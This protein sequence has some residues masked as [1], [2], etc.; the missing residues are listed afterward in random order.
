MLLN[1]KCLNM[2]VYICDLGLNRGIMLV[3]INTS[4]YTQD[5]SLQNWFHI[6]GN[7]FVIVNFS[8]DIKDTSP[9]K[10]KKNLAKP[11][12]S[13]PKSPQLPSI[14]LY[15]RSDMWYVGFSLL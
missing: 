12:N 1:V 13:P 4:M 7:N 11:H 8:L 9:P 10:K 15:W 3:P 14:F 5:S 6:G 2:C